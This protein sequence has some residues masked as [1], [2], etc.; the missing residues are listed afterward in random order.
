MWC[1][2]LLF[3]VITWVVIA[4]LMLC[5]KR[6]NTRKRTIG[7]QLCC[8]MLIAVFCT[9][10]ARLCHHRATTSLFVVASDAGAVSG[11]AGG[12]GLLTGALVANYVKFF[13]DAQVS[14]VRSH[15]CGVCTSSSRRGVPAV[16]KSS[17]HGVL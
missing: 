5:F 12:A 14:I 1:G 4:A 15:V 8:A 9:L 13:T 2:G 7:W 10:W 17:S 11:W 6:P 3:V 16:L